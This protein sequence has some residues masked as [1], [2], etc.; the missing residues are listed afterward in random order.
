MEAHWISRRYKK[1]SFT[2]PLTFEDKVKIF[3]DRVEGWQLHISRS[4]Y[5]RIPHGGFGALY[6]CLSYFEMIARY[7][8]GSI[9]HDNSNEYFRSGFTCFSKRIG[10]DSDPNF[11]IVRKLILKGVRNGLYHICMTRDQVYIS[12]DIQHVFD[13][14]ASTSKLVINPGLLIEEILADF[15][16]YISSL[17]NISKKTLRN[18]FERKFD[19]DILPQIK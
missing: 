14:D 6:I 5:K 11:T 8:Q 16:D 10:F 18:H 2:F 9:D 7:R 13:Y 19:H 17:R 1:S 15:K 4:C 3:K 12:G